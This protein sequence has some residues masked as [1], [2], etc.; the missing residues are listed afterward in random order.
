MRRTLR[1]GAVCA[2][3]TVVAV[4]GFAGVAS[5]HVTVSPSSAIAGGDVRIAFRVPTESGT[6]STVKVEVQVPTDKPIPSVAVEPVPGWSVAT[7]TT[8]LATPV[9]T[10]EGD[11]ITDAVSV[12]TWTATSADSAIKPGQ[13]QEFPVALESLPDTDKIVF[14]AVQT[15]S[16]G[17]VVRWIDETTEGQPEPDHPAPVLALAK[18]GDTAPV[19]AT[20]GGTPTVATAG[21][22]KPASGTTPLV[23][24]IVALVLGLVGAALGGVAFGRTRRSADTGPGGSTTT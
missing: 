10:D 2:L 12:I 13:F 23:L 17:T 20:S 3:A 1:A 7:T 19:A 15:Y 16:D 6:A 4:L 5:A 11:T 18:S 21:A 22:T 8:K 9:K 24:S 14:K